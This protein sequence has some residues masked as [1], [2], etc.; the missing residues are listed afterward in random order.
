MVKGMEW[1]A[2]FEVFKSN[3]TWAMLFRKPLL[4]IFNAVHNYKEDTI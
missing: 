4:K 3:G 2:T 1:K